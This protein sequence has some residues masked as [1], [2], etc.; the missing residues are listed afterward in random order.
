MGGI[1][2]SY[3][4]GDS[5]LYAGRLRDTLSHHFGAEQVF[6]DIDSVDP[7]ERFP[8]L[9]EQEVGS[10]D[11]LLALIG[12][13]W[14]AVTDDEGTRRL[15][16]PDDYVRREIATALDRDD[17]LV[18]PVLVGTTS[19]PAA[20]DLPKPLAS[21]ADCQL[22]RLS[23]EYWDDQV[24]RLTRAVE[25]VVKP[26]VAAPLRLPFAAPQAEVSAAGKMGA[27]AASPVA[28]WLWRKIRP[29]TSRAAL[30]GDADR[31]AEAIS[32][33]ET[34]LLDQLRAG[35]DSVM[36]LEFRAWSQVQSAGGGDIGV[37][38]NVGP[39]FRRLA[40]PRRLLVVG[41]AGAGKTVLAVRL[42]LDQLHH[43][44]ALTDDLRIDTPVP[45]RV[46][47]AGWDGG[48][49]FTSW[50]ASRLGIDYPLD[51]KVAQALT[52]A[53]Y[54]LPVL[55]GLDEM[56]PPDAEPHRARVALDRLNEPPWRNRAVVVM[57]RT[58][59]YARI[60]ELRGDAGLHG[61]TTITL[62]PLSP[63]QIC[64]YLQQYRDQLGVPEDAWG[65][66][67]DQIGHDPDGPLAT[68]L[69]TP[70]LLGLAVTALGRDHRTATQ[71]AACR[72]TTEIRDRL[73]AAL[74][75][76]AIQGA[77]RTGP[78]RDYTEQKVQTWM[79]TLAQHLERRR[80]E[81]MG[82]TEITLGEVWALAGARR[83]R[84][85]YAVVT[86]L[87]NGL[88]MGLLIR[89]VL[90]LPPLAHLFLPWVGRP[91]P[92]LFAWGLGLLF[93]L[94]SALVLWKRET[95]PKPRKGITRKGIRWYALRISG[96]SEMPEPGAPRRFAWRVPGR[97]RWRKGL[98]AGLVPV[99]WNVP[100]LVSSASGLTPQ[101]VFGALSV[102]SGISIGLTIG[103]GTNA[104]D[105]LA[106]GQDA[107]RVIHDDLVAGLISAAWAGVCGLAAGL[108]IGFSMGRAHVLVFGLVGLVVGV[109][110]GMSGLVPAVCGRYAIASLLFAFTE[111]FPARPVQFLEWARNAGLL[112]V[113]GIAYQFR[114]DT[115]QQWLAAGA[116]DRVVKTT[117]DSSNRLTTLITPQHAQAATV[118]AT[119]VSSGQPSNQPGPQLAASLPAERRPRGRPC[120][121]A[122]ARRGRC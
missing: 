82:G 76:A 47:V 68:A 50:M 69:R 54:I 55:D 26:R 51:P 122:H 34:G 12:P 120:R 5:G 99:L 49:D 100:Y 73:F 40:S 110:A 1:F 80:A 85:L 77:R 24:A 105:R 108:A 44:A 15:D 46:N 86:G 81:G 16:D 52:E 75:P 109:V 65:A 72:D 66:V 92:G 2:I 93:G 8:R 62:Q 88:A 33:R 4:R 37:L 104:E 57:C 53:G 106:L 23:D 102:V 98:A 67:T 74:I 117:L 3:R 70:W 115:Y 31:L 94:W 111:I 101:R 96:R 10:C 29:D 84:A 58:G 61:A 19:M 90:G 35:P 6:R 87:T 83:G 119:T 103:L 22:A 18:I 71:L 36:D 63:T 14:L 13:T 45:V 38:S 21:L 79:H 112:R 11:A 64:D 78:T 89:L 118:A 59:V 48:G 114:H 121:A 30:L 113:T 25:K 7:G 41:E 17:V 107:R 20:A 97:S 56:D 43:R 27:G 42:L 39:Y 116:V 28:R 9:I 91:L 32:R 95:D 60:R